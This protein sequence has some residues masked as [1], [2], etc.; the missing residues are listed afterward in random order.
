MS[1][2]DPKNEN[3]EPVTCKQR[4]AATAKA[5]PGLGLKLWIPERASWAAKCFFG[6]EWFQSARKWVYKEWI[7]NRRDDHYRE[8]VTD[9]ETGEVLHHC[10]EPLSEHR[11][12]G[13]AKSKK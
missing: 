5:R 12:H 3:P 13:S 6:Y 4:I 11:G 2:D 10:D 7:I 9:P 8:V 1:K